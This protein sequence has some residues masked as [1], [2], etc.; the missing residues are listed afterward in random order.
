MG[1][2]CAACD[3]PDA[4]WDAGRRSALCTP[5]ELAGPTAR[6]PLRLGD[7]LAATGDAL[8]FVARTAT[9]PQR[10]RTACRECGAPAEW[11]RTTGGRWMLMEP[12]AQTT[13]SVPPGR[14]WRVAGDGTA[15]NLRGAA[16]SGNCR[17]SHFDVCPAHTAPPDTT[18]LL[19]L[20]QR[21]ARQR[22]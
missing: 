8:T 7:I 12:G 1:F 15:V 18:T 17:V 21:N 20:W 19:T 11:Y 22:A 16:P 10:G 4:H 5:C 14:R 6:D 13:A 2:R 9:A 3:G